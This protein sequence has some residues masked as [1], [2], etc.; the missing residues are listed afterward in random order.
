MIDRCE[1]ASQREPEAKRARAFLTNLRLY[2]RMTGYDHQN[3]FQEFVQRLEELG[4]EAY[5]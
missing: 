5:E 4:S 3:K 2:I 1:G